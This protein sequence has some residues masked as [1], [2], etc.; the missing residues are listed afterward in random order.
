MSAEP[1]VGTEILSA[2]RAAAAN[3]RAAAGHE[4]KYENQMKAAGAN[5]FHAF[6]LAIRSAPVYKGRKLDDAAVLRIYKST[7]PRQWW[8]EHLAAAKFVDGRGKA[9]REHAARL[10]QWHV[11]LEG[12]RA[13]RAKHALSCVSTRKRVEK[14]RGV[15]SY[16]SR[17]N[18]KSAPS[19]E[20][21]RELAA[22]QG[23]EN[24]AETVI[25][26]EDLLGEVNRLSSAAK[27]VE[28][29]H[30]AEAL[31]AVRQAARQIERYVP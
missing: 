6:T 17:E 4:D 13:R 11:D 12:A 1:S 24:A 9:D 28:P 23:E 15:A 14:Q 2:I 19:T 5:M 25:S 30:R 3:E 26:V 31:E 10:I 20:E 21:M 8:D 7:S 18:R 29:A 22:G 16:G 27:K